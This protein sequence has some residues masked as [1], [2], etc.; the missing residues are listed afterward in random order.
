ML[1]FEATGGTLAIRR[2]ELRHLLEGLVH[3][4]VQ[5]QL[6]LRT[7]SLCLQVLQL[8]FA[9]S[10]YLLVERI[11]LCLERADA[12]IHIVLQLG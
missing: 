11:D 3:G 4:V 12:G 1:L 2:D 5:V 10:R 9:R 7:I 6:A 8:G